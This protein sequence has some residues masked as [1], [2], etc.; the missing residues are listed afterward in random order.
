MKQFLHDVKIKTY[1]TLIIKNIKIPLGS[2]RESNLKSQGHAMKKRS[3]MKIR[4]ESFFAFLLRFPFASR[5]Q[6]LSRVYLARDPRESNSG[7]NGRRAKGCMVFFFFSSF[8]VLELLASARA[9]VYLSQKGSRQARVK[10]RKREEKREDTGCH[11]MRCDTLGCSSRGSRL[12]GEPELTI[13]G[14][15]N[16]RKW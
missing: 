2:K 15:D 6:F 11:E 1:I 9:R 5:V 16:Y 14:Y 7:R 3:E 8:L 4:E 13:V 12:L 10:G